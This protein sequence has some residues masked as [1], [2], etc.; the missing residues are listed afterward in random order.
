M[1]QQGAIM[2]RCIYVW[3]S[4]RRK[5]KNRTE[6]VSK[7]QCLEFSQNDETSSHT[8]WKKTQ[9]YTHTHL[10]IWKYIRKRSDRLP[11]R[12]QVLD[13][14]LT[15]RQSNGSQKTETMFPD[16][17]RKLLLAQLTYNYC[18]KLLYNIA[19]IKFYTSVNIFE[20]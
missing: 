15:S 8:E 7:T 4:T 2:R 19:Y 9:P 12:D 14:Q 17:Q 16:T 6:A 13:Y 5:K 20:K 10:G 18:I 1:P 3:N 11:P